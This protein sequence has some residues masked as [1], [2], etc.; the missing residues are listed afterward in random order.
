[1]E[2]ADDDWSR[3]HMRRMI[4]TI[5]RLAANT[6]KL[7]KEWNQEREVEMNLAMK[8]CKFC[9]ADIHPGAIICRYCQGIQDMNRYEKEFKVAPAT[10]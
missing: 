2:A 9:F 7:P 3:Y 5:Q 10:Q 1:V 8:P 4:S 6:L